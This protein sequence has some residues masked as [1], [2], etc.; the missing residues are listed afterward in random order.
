MQ[1]GIL[2]LLL[3]LTIAAMAYGG[4]YLLGTATPR[5]LQR[6]AQPELAWLQHEF[7]LSDT[8]LASVAQLHAGYL[9]R[10]MERCRQINGINDRLASALASATTVTPEL[11]KLLHERAQLRAACQAEMLQHFFEVSRT[12]PLEQGQRYLA[13]ARNNTCLRE[14]T[15]DHLQDIHSVKTAPDR[16]P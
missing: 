12:M 2:I 3:G 7:K 5:S 15:M 4:F 1:R 11:E 16:H 13:W 14:Q 9:P 10:C 6:S 8:T